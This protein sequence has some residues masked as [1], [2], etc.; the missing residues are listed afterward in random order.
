M[1]VRF[2]KTVTTKEAK[3]QT[4]KAGDEVDFYELYHAEGP[5]GGVSDED[6]ARVCRIRAEASANHWINR[7]AAER[8]EDDAKTR[9]GVKAAPE[10]AKDPAKEPVPAIKDDPAKKK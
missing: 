2:T 5:K 4:F 10:V 3:P 8:V 9:K 1:K 7:G 6:F